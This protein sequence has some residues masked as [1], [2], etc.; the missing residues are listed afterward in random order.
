MFGFQ[1]KKLGI[2]VGLQKI[3]SGLHKN[4]FR[5]TGKKQVHPRIL[6]FGAITKQNLHKK[7]DKKWDPFEEFFKEVSFGE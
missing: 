3:L 6:K 1:K 7:G 2:L 5:I 4:F